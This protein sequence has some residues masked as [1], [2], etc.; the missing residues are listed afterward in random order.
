MVSRTIRRCPWSM[1][2]HISAIL[3]VAPSTG[4]H[5]TR[6]SPRRQL[7]RK[8]R[9]R[10]VTKRRTFRRSEIAT[11]S[12]TFSIRQLVSFLS[13]QY[14]SNVCYIKARIEDVEP[15]D[16]VELTEEQEELAQLLHADFEIGDTFRHN[17]IPRAVIYYTGEGI[18]DDD[19]DEDLGEFDEDDFDDFDEDEDLDDEDEEEEEEEDEEGGKN[20]KPK[21]HGGISKKKGTQKHLKN[22][23]GGDQAD[24]PQECKQQ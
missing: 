5:L 7:S 15:A 9:I 20:D 4:S 18:Q 11:L 6:M 23:K 21:K 12:S 14:Y 10:T 13:V 22:G 17:V 16:G 1:M 2:D 8:L 24:T 19:Y 3:E